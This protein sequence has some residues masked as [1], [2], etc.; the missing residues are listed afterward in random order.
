M[1]YL[2]YL[3]LITLNYIL[4]LY[5]T[6]SFLIIDK[7]LLKFSMLIR[8]HGKDRM[9]RFVGLGVLL[10][11]SL[12]KEAV[13]V[14]LGNKNKIVSV[15]AKSLI[16]DLLTRSVLIQILRLLHFFLTLSVTEF[17]SC[18]PVLFL[19]EHIL[20]NSFVLIFRSTLHS[21]ERLN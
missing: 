8:Y 12:P 5:S 13:F 16:A 21:Q 1:N 2:K 6:G 18:L 17:N 3:V 15:T 14:I 4:K 20:I 19:A 10:D 9:G 11:L 7:Y